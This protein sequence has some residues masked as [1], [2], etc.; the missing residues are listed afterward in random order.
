MTFGW[1]H[2]KLSKQGEAEAKLEV[3]RRRMAIT[4]RQRTAT[5]RAQQVAAAVGKRPALATAGME[6]KPKAKSAK[7]TKIV[8]GD[9][10]IVLSERD[11]MRVLA[12]LENPPDPPPAL[13]AAAQRMR[14]RQSSKQMNSG[15]IKKR[16]QE[17]D[18]L[19]NRE[20]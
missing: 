4:A 8:L 11:T 10:P 20:S 12:F 17:I 18:W 2:G 5:A 19:G 7:Q 14:Q 3:R 13:V 6:K 15:E 1:G 9:R 16:A